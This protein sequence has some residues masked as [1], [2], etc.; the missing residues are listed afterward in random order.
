MGYMSRAG[1]QSSL[2]DLANDREPSA[3]RQRAFRRILSWRIPP[4]WSAP[5]WFDEVKA[6]TAAA[7][8][9]AELDY[10]G[11]RGV[12]LS[13]FLY[14]RVLTCAWTRY[15]QEWSY[16]LRFV[17]E[18]GTGCDEA[19]PAHP[20]LPE[21]C[22]SDDSLQCA[23]LELPFADQWLVRQLFW[24]SLSQGKVAQKLKITQQA[25]SKRKRKI[26]RKLRQLLRGTRTAILLSGTLFLDRV[27]DLIELPLSC[28]LWL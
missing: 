11:E 3:A 2:H 20:G 28:D 7:C 8:C 1:G 18:K 24:N 21:R 13:A 27:S 22:A 26:I 5:D 19:T 17:Q 14:Q 12:P 6:I 4:N 23:L 10:D 25:V 15:R 9:R 16:A